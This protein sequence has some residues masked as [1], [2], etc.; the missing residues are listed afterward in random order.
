MGYFTLYGCFL[1]LL[2][3]LPSNTATCPSECSCTQ[4]DRFV[5][6]SSKGLTELPEN[7]QD[8]IISLNISH[9]DIKDLDDK[10]KNFTNLRF[11][12]ISN[13]LLTRMP[14]EFPRALWEIY[15][16]NN[17]IKVL[18][19]GDTVTQWNLRTLDLSNNLI[20][21]SYLI[22]NTLSSLKL[23][24]FSGNRFW[25]I[26]TN[27]PHNLEV[28]DLSHNN[29]QNILPD[30]FRQGRLSKLYLNNNS[31]RLIPNGTFDQLTNLQLITLYGNLWQCNSQDSQFYL[32]TWVKTVKATVLGYPCTEEAQFANSDLST[33]TLPSHTSAFTGQQ[34]EIKTIISTRPRESEANTSQS[35]TSQETGTPSFSQLV[36]NAS[37]NSPAPSSVSEQIATKNISIQT[38]STE[39]SN[40]TPSVTNNTTNGP[41]SPTMST[42]TPEFT[43]NS[44]VSTKSITRANKSNGTVKSQTSGSMSRSTLQPTAIKSHKSTASTTSSTVSESI[45]IK[46]T[47]S[48]AAIRSITKTIKVF[49]T[50][51][52]TAPKMNGITGTTSHVNQH[53][54]TVQSPN[55]KA[56]VCTGIS[57]YIIVLTM[58]VSLVV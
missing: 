33:V 23:L 16:A 17:R 14:T 36:T 43:S 58:L 50:S 51:L 45:T 48:H 32:L 1:A 40:N 11:L 55:S 31:F 44:T 9:N 26:P 47:T 7:I 4:N 46:A 19:K 22:K 2:S 42:I 37:L 39:S 34:T 13:N 20:K 28:L 5:D 29:L 10:L 8:N 38:G 53:V 21:R 6:C 54:T 57:L 12:D 27:T 24:N 41:S 3:I 52:T 56:H 49:P 35:L 30:T 18:E 25:A 15:A